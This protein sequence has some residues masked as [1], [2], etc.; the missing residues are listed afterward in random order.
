MTTSPKI[1]RSGL[2]DRSVLVPA[3]DDLR[4]REGFVV[5]LPEQYALFDHIREAAGLRLADVVADLLPRVAD[6]LQS[7]PE[8]AQPLQSEMALAEAALC[9]AISASSTA[10]GSGFTAQSP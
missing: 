7:L 6:E 3:S 5:T 9:R 1:G 10:L 2:M 4:R 8:Q